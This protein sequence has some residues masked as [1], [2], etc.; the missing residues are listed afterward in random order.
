[1]RCS[2]ILKGTYQNVCCDIWCGRLVFEYYP[3]TR[4]GSPITCAWMRFLWFGKNNDFFVLMTTQECLDPKRVELEEM[5]FVSI[6]KERV[7]KYDSER[8]VY[9]F[10][11]NEISCGVWRFGSLSACGVGEREKSKE[12]ERKDLIES[13][14]LIGELQ[15]RVNR[16]ENKMGLYNLH[17]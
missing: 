16:S 6:K 1:M 11:R 17:Q 15:T 3:C 13:K 8:E 14:F 7:K 2:Y 5:F 4:I 9:L 10:G 12:E